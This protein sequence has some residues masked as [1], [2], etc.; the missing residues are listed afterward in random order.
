VAKI[1]AKKNGS[2]DEVVG[3]KEGKKK[4]KKAPEQVYK[5]TGLI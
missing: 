1:S 5:K 2:M 3:K 4:K